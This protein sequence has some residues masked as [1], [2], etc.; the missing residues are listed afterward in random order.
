MGKR[1]VRYAVVG[2]GYFAQKAIL[3]AFAHA[4]KNSQ[5]VALVS[6]DPRKL[7][8]LVKLYDVARSLPYDDFD[9][10]CASGDIDAVYLAVPNHKHREYTERAARHGVHVLVEKPMAVT[11]E[12]CEA[13]IA[14]CRAGQ[15][16]LMIAYRLHF[17]ASNLRALD[18]V[19]RKKLGEPRFFNSSFS[20][21][22]AADNVRLNPAGEGGGALYDIG[23][24]CINAARTLFGDEPTEV[25]CLAARGSDPRFGAVDEQ[26]QVG[27][28]FPGERLASFVV[29]FGAVATDSYDVVGTK[30]ALRLEPAYSYIGGRQQRLTAGDKTETKK[31]KPHDQIAAEVIYFSDCILAGREPEP[32]GL[33]GLADVRVVR[34]ALR[35]L[36]D[37]RPV[38]LTSPPRPKH[39]DPAAQKISRPPVEP[40][41]PTVAVRPES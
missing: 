3:P 37:G 5:L 22:I 23:V 7:K 19:R 28:R 25:S 18:L 16:R 26:Y 34:A 35:S 30:G 27:L 1:K 8:K 29:G 31:W 10:L 33:E 21:Q 13:M 6:G 14:A 9:A 32:D 41:P 40:D 38:P 15:A 4:S 2:L 24:Y 17:E 20:F 39:P 11:E 36:G 12:D